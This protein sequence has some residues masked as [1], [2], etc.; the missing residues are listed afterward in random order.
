MDQERLEELQ[1]EIGTLADSLCELKERHA[2]WD[3]YSSRLTTSRV[4]VFFGDFHDWA[5]QNYCDAMAI[6]IRRLVFAGKGTS[7]LL[8]LMRRVLERAES[9]TFNDA[10]TI[11]G[12]D[13]DDRATWLLASGFF[14]TSE[15][16]I[17]KAAVRRDS[18][19]IESSELLGRCKKCADTRIAHSVRGPV[20]G[21]A[22]Q[23]PALKDVKPVLELLSSQIRRYRRLLNAYPHCLDPEVLD[24]VPRD[25]DS[26][27][28][29]GGDRP[30]GS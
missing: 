17:S 8:D 26:L 5:F 29:K 4:T 7:S 16:T 19:V 11:Q 24:S 6:G 30:L 20:R 15:R 28:G 23:D 21:P 27:F 10:V 1:K 25:L 3:A 13:Q 9:F 12:L 14:S 2:I 18:H 22:P